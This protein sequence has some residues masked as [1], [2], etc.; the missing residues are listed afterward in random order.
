M[1]LHWGLHFKSRF[2]S[3]ICFMR[4][5]YF[6]LLISIGLR[7]YTQ[8][9]ENNPISISF[10]SIS[11]KV[12]SIKGWHYDTNSGMWIEGDNAIYSSE[13]SK[14]ENSI[15]RGVESKLYSII[16]R[17]LKYKDK[18]Y[19]AISFKT[20]L[21]SSIFIFKKNEIDKIKKLK[22][23]DTLT[24]KYEFAISE[25]SDSIELLNEIRK[26][27]NSHLNIKWENSI[28]SG[29]LFFKAH[30]GYIRFNLPIEAYLS[31]GYKTNIKNYY[32]EVEFS[33]FNKIFKLTNYTE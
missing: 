27:I 4:T 1:G 25:N 30:K 14:K 18:P 32:Y 17:E 19:N 31:I 10:T 22:D 23:G 15:S 6:I 12:D 2:F 29:I 8:D 9:R 26:E 11:E 21:S 24:I 5:L 7:G 33:H 13:E 3:Y 16:N 28:S 20:E